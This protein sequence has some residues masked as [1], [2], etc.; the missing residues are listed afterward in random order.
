M[1]AGELGDG[2]NP[3]DGLIMG[4]ERLGHAVALAQD[5][6]TL[7]YAA[8]HR[9]PLEINLVSNLRLQVVPSLESHPFLT[10]LRLGLPVSL[11]TDDEGIFATDIVNECRVAIE[12]SDVTYAELKQMAYNSVTTAFLPEPDRAALVTRLEAQFAA[13]EREQGSDRPMKRAAGY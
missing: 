10:F 2:R 8:R 5:P 9:V 4:A 6:V 11:S 13:F 12:S 3:R 7:E 1:H